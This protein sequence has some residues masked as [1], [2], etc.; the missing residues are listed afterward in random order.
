MA[1]TTE[2]AVAAIIE[3]D[4]TI[5]LAPFIEI[6]AELVTE[7]TAGAGY[8]AVRLE[9]IERWLS[10]HFYA[11]R[12]MRAASERAGPVAQS[13]QFKV[14]LNLANTMYGQQVMMIDTAGGFA[15]LSKRSEK[16]QTKSVSVLWLGTGNKDGDDITG[17]PKTT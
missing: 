16:G 14:G 4:A 2:A 7:V 11:I 6:A 3:V 17:D 1:L 15:A 13:F 8:T 5:P 12:D 10:A 9:L